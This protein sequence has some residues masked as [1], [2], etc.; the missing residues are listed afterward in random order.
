MGDG[1]EVLGALRV[2]IEREPRRPRMTDSAPDS[3]RAAQLRAQ[4][5]RRRVQQRRA[6]YGGHR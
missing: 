6:R 1:L 3:D 2:P 5:R 4:R